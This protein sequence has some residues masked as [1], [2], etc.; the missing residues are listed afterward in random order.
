MVEIYGIKNC[1]S[2][3]KAL[4]FLEKNSIEYRFV[5]LRDSFE[6][7]NIG[8]WLT[9][10]DI[11][12]LFNRRGRKYRELNL[13]KESLNDS[14]MAKLLCKEPLLIKRP[15]AVLENGDLIVGFEET[16]YKE[17]FL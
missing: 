6:C 8:R 16:K 15:V 1:D 13:S 14:Q 4:R 2:V 10:V 7:E 12:T 3:K 9:K 17:R 5:D 11:T